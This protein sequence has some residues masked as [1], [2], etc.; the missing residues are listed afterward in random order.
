MKHLIRAVLGLALCLFAGESCHLE[1]VPAAPAASQRHGTSDDPNELITPAPMRAVSRAGGSASPDGGSGGNDA[2]IRLGAAAGNQ[3]DGGRGGS[4]TGASAGTGGSSQQAPAAGSTA[5]T[6]GSGGAGGV[7]GI[8]QIAGSGSEAGR[9]ATAGSGGS[10]M[11]VAG[12]GVGGARGQAGDG[13][14]GADGKVA[15]FDELIDQ[16][17]NALTP[18]QRNRIVG[19]LATNS[20]T[21]D[22]LNE[23]L[24]SVSN[25]GA[26]DGGHDS[27]QQMCRLVLSACPRCMINMMMTNTELARCAAL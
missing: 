12:R 3:G 16:L 25:A 21:P 6:S 10:Q 15:T 8:G 9:S 11:P 27:C 5:S 2:V 1:T 23:L 4:S 14:S 17:S 19:A 24:D 20:V 22:Q 26:C 13:T 18:E 7:G